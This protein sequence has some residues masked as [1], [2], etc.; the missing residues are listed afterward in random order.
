[1]YIELIY[2]YI[3]ILNNIFNLIILR[4]TIIE[5]KL[6]YIITCRLYVMYLCHY[7]INL[8]N[9]YFDIPYTYFML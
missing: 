2:I 9:F 8:D 4:M 7:V 3:Y 6:V 5:Y 1:M